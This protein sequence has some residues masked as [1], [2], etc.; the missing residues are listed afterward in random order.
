MI[1]SRRSQYQ[2]LSARLL[3]FPY[4]LVNIELPEDFSGVKQMLVLKDPEIS[5]ISVLALA[6]LCFYC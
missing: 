6:W 5:E 1:P 2:D 3:S 4:L